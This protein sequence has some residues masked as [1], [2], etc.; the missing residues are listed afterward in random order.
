M[1][2]LLE[3][4]DPDF[5]T[6]ANYDRACQI[7]KNMTTRIPTNDKCRNVGVLEVLPSLFRIREDQRPKV[8][9]MI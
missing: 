8:G 7:L 2:K 1:L 5:Y 4:P 6:N 3:T 9:Q